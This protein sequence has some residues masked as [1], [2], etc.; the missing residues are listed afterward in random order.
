MFKRK[1]LNKTQAN[2]SADVVINTNSQENFI[3]LSLFEIVE[4]TAYLKADMKI[5]KKD[6][7]QLNKRIERLENGK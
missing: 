7:K 2:N 6:I 4:N 1:N 5:I 3:Q